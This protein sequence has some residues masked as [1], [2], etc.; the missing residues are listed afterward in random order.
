MMHQ[1]N[2]LSP[3]QVG[4]HLTALMIFFALP[5]HLAVTKDH[6]SVGQHGKMQQ[7]NVHTHVKVVSVL[8]A[9]WGNVLV[10]TYRSI[11]EPRLFEVIL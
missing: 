4:C 2:V 5:A 10:S 6:F 7:Q 3:V 1:L 8:I 9:P 11:H